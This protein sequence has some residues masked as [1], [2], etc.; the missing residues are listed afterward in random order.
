KIDGSYLGSRAEN[1]NTYFRHIATL[2][3][4]VGP[5]RI[6]FSDNH[7]RNTFLQGDT[8]LQSNS[9]QWYEWEG[10]IVNADSA[11]NRYKV[12]YKER[13]DWKSDSSQL[14]RAAV[15]RSIGAQFDWVTNEHSQLSTIASYRVL[16]IQQPNLMNQDPAKTFIGK[17]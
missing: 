1:K 17:I 15:A 16:D 3:Q 4:K 2:S 6:G 14:R 11:N 12:F 13:Y 10:F 8:L 9:Y 7:E 5:I